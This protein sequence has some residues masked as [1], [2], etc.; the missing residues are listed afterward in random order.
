MIVL[1]RNVSGSFRFLNDILAQIST[2]AVAMAFPQPLHSFLHFL[3]YFVL[4]LETEEGDKYTQVSSPPLHSVSTS[5]PAHMQTS[6]CSDREE[7]G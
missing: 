7:F 5:S 1:Y 6:T 2:K 4:N 3:T